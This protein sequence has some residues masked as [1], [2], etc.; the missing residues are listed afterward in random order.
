MTMGKRIGALVLC[1]GT[2]AIAQDSVSTHQGL[3][4]DAIGAYT[5][6][7]QV[8]RYV[9]DLGNLTS[10]WGTQFGIAPLMKNSQSFS[11]NFFSRFSGAQSMSVSS[12]YN[13]CR[14]ASSFDLWT[15]P[16]AGVNASSNTAGTPTA[17]PTRGVQFGVVMGENE[18]DGNQI[19]PWS[20][21]SVV[22]GVVFYDPKNAGRLYVTRVQAA[23]NG[24]SHLQ[25]T[26]AF[27]VGGV[28]ANGNTSFR[29]DGFGAIGPNQ[30]LDN[31]YYRV[32]LLSRNPGSLNVIDA[33]G[34]TDAAA[35]DWIDLT[36]T[37]PGNGS[38]TSHNCPTMIPQGFGPRPV[39]IG[40]NFNKEYVFEQV[41]G[42]LSSDDPDGGGPLLSPRLAVPGLVDHRGNIYFSPVQAFSD[43]VGTCT[44]IAA[45]QASAPYNDVILW[46]VNADGSVA[47]D[48]GG[49]PKVR[50]L[51]LPG[52]LVDN[53][54]L[55]DV[56][57]AWSPTWSHGF[58]NYGSQTAFQGG[59]GA[60]ALGRDQAGRTILSGL[61]HVKLGAAAAFGND[62][63]PHNVMAVA[64]ITGDAMT[65]TVEWTMAGH[66]YR[67]VALNNG[68]AIKNGSG[69]SPVGR[70]IRMCE[71]TQANPGPACDAGN[72]LRRGPSMS[73]PA[74][75]SVGN[76]YYLA[77]AELYDAVGAIRDRDSVLVRAVYNPATFSYELEQIIE[78]GNVFAGLNS[79]KNYQLSF[80]SIVDNNS[81]GSDSMF[82]GNVLQT[83]AHDGPTGALATSDAR[84]LGGLVL[85]ARIVYDVNGDGQFIPDV[86]PFDPTPS[87]EAYQVLMFIG[88]STNGTFCAADIN[89]DGILNIAD[90]GAFQ[91]GFA[92]QHPRG[93]FNCDT[94]YNIADFGA[95]QTAFAIG[96][97]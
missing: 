88:P 45:A 5:T 95:F 15:T 40:T 25:N 92:T 69:G 34:A 7:E 59:N 70:L 21:N 57:A 76:I 58:R 33:A 16:G 10:S 97:P 32:K 87:D 28:D 79:G 18:F 74:I 27:G 23:N 93:D 96:C 53:D 38:S 2:A 30:L 42:V 65:G 71:I 51:T 80:L 29:A 84:T 67:S 50:R 47:T 43:T 31:N 13:V 35:T 55:W 60:I 85:T 24:T 75:D 83:A 78:P 46:G 66:N 73:A 86:D 17:P 77:A 14:P 3:P 41:A 94:L 90:F 72:T 9:V 54:D 56:A 11:P 63:N 6:P 12:L 26:A 19:P 4:G 36:P 81:I 48:G 22:G 52:T 39:M 8:N 20:V 82:S 68:K 62:N 64:R 44:M 61:V 91:T 37:L 49:N 1:C 89:R